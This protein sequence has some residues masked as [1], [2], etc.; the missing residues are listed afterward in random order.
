VRRLLSN[1]LFIYLF[2]IYLIKA[3][4]QRGFDWMTGEDE[5]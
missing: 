4:F 2:Y 5:A 1:I 3:I